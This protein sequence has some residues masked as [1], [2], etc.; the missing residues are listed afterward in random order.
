MISLIIPMYNSEQTIANTLNSV[1]E[2]TVPFSEVIVV[3]NGSKDRSSE[4]VSEFA[5][6]YS[7]INL[8]F[9]ETQGV[10]AARNMGIDVAKSEYISF[11]DAD[12]ILDPHYVENITKT[13][14]EHPSA[15]MYHFNFYQQFKNG[16]IKQNPYF[17]HDRELY[18]GPEFMQETLNRFSFEA[19]HMV[20]TF[21]FKKKFLNQYHLRFNTE[22]TIF[23]DVL[24]L[25]KAWSKS[26]NLM[27]IDTELVTYC[28]NGF[29][30]TNNKD[31][32][33]LMK[34]LSVLYNQTEENLMTVKYLEKLTSRLLD[35]KDYFSFWKQ[36]RKITSISIY[37]QFIID[38]I[39]YFIIR[40]KRKI[41]K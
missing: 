27:I 21:V 14:R 17:L 13:I 8:L 22:M 1:I 35:K 9:C 16:I 40:I 11:L 19:K 12:D 20:W 34:N 37:K 4:I 15:E 3:D 31:K 6:Q 24:F 41:C 18:S 28:W 29:S 30:I 39:E 5:Q 7:Y 2:Q 25:H 33:Q 36:N 10:S 23:E 32:K 38:K 26:Q